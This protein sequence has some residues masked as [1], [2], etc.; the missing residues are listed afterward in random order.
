MN[1]TVKESSIGGI[2]LKKNPF[3]RYI[4]VY[5]LVSRYEE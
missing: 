4:Y 3:Y 5:L 1:K 2:A